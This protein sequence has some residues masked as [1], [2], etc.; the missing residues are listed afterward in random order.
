MVLDGGEQL[1][2][3]T[4][5]VIGHA[6]AVWNELGYGFLEKVYENALM[7]ALSDDTINVEQQKPIPVYFREQL[8]GE[9]VAD[10]VVAHELLIELKSAKEIAEA[11][12]AQL[13]NYLKATGLRTGLI[14]NFGPKGVQVKRFR[15]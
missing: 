6:Y 7:I 14:L 5:R 1:N 4:E 15:K 3:L 12:K 11:H 10:L 13:L 9:Y 2:D 8:I